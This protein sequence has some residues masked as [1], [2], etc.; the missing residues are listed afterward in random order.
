MGHLIYNQSCRWG[1]QP[2]FEDNGKILTYIDAKER[3]EKHREDR[4]L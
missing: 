2:E 1:L 3:R 4:Q